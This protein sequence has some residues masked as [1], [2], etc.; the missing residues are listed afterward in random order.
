MI[1]HKKANEKKALKTEMVAAA[2]LEPAL[3]FPRS[4]F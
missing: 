2:G 1:R 4:R 3:R